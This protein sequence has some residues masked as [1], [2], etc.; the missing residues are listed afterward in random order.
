M[1]SAGQPIRASDVAVQGC[2]ITRTTTQSIAHSTLVEIQFDAEVFD[3][4]GMHS[5]STN[6]TRITIN[7]AG[8]WDIGFNGSYVTGADYT[9]TE[10]IIRVNGSLEI[11]R[12]IRA[13]VPSQIQSI[14]A[15]TVYQFSVGDYIE[16]VT[17]Q[18]NGASTAR[19]LEA[20]GDRTPQA[21]AVRLG[22]GS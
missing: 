1:V 5:T 8:I 9:R 4:D 22:S 12:D 11:A 3:N 18:V 17:R 20:I 14:S 2:R 13:G 21:Y 10:I 19:N 15:N 7:T 16:F 6:N